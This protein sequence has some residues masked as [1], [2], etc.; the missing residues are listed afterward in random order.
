[1]S[2]IQ[3]TGMKRQHLTRKDALR[4][5]EWLKGNYERLEGK[6]VGEG[7]RMA[8][9]QLGM[10]VSST[11]IARLTQEMGYEP[12]WKAHA[13]ASGDQEMK[14]AMRMLVKTMGMMQ[15]SLN[16]HADAI[17]MLKQ[18]GDNLVE[19]IAE[20][21]KMAG[22]SILPAKPY[23]EHVRQRHDGFELICES[24][25]SGEWKE[26]ARFNEMSN[27][28]AYTEAMNVCRAK[29]REIAAKGMMNY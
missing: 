12:F 11:S 20:L 3:E 6:T 4:L 2:T 7:A 18:V 19:R 16:S 15:A 25:E 1:M 14:E 17:N 29:M 21:E 27:D 5:Y 24:N 10:R 13:K 23:G 26:F 22:K 8:G 9:D 28:L